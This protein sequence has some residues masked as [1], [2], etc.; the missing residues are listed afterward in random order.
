MKRLP[1][2]VRITV[3]TT[4]NEL[5]NISENDITASI[6]L[7]GY[8]TTGLY[9]VPVEVVPQ[10]HLLNVDSIEINVRPR[11]FQITLDKKEG[12]Y[13]PVYPHYNGSVAPGYE[14]ASQRIVPEQIWI[15]GPQ[16]LVDN[17]KSIP[18]EIIEL[19]GRTANI[20]R[21]VSI[22]KNRI[23]DVLQTNITNFQFNAEVSII[24]QEKEWN[25]LPVVFINLSDAY[26]IKI[27]G[28]NDAGDVENNDIDGGENDDVIIKATLKLRSNKRDVS[29][30]EPAQDAVTV[31]C[32]Q[33]TKPGDL[34]MTVTVNVPA[35][36]QVIDYEPKTILINV[37]PAD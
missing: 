5:D 10:T 22:D 8:T 7:S 37:E 31:D 11:D 6:D 35:E 23:G 20:S 2:L 1:S 24:E 21:V 18:T 30:Y 15:E 34:T 26:K 19:T 16:S 29:Y 4:K 33:I 9:N 3:V 27:P 28:V 25:G 14:L 13:V 12:K 36:F 32:S 17:I